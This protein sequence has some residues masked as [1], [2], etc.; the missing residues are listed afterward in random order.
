MAGLAPDLWCVGSLAPKAQKKTTNPRKTQQNQKKLEKRKKKNKLRPDEP[1]SR[2]FC[3]F[4]V[5]FV[6][7]KLT[8]FIIKGMQQSKSSKSCGIL[9]FGNNNSRAKGEI[10]R[11]NEVIANIASR[12]LKV[13]SIL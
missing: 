2:W 5:C 6:F 7:L 13:L 3:Y 11:S 1:F 8:V 4:L 10:Q 9:S 12:M